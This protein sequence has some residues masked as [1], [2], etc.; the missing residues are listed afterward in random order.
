M[1][2][3]RQQALDLRLRA[4]DSQ[5]VGARYFFIYYRWNGVPGR[6]RH[7]RGITR[8]P[9]PAQHVSYADPVTGGSRDGSLADR[10]Y[11]CQVKIWA[12]KEC[13][14]IRL[15]SLFR[16]KVPPVAPIQTGCPSGQPVSRSTVF[17]HSLRST[18]S[19]ISGTCRRSSGQCSI[20]APIT[21]LTQT[22]CRTDAMSE[23][24]E[25]TNWMQIL[26]RVAMLGAVTGYIIWI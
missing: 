8:I 24:H 25:D 26:L 20:T 18:V 7:H 5:C 9:E 14:G 3:P 11:P 17:A 6:Q 2:R 21:V 15:D 4:P 1:L 22:T 19:N 23:T 10:Q 12:T 16:F 13:F